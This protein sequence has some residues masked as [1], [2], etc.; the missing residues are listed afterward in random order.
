MKKR[1]NFIL[2]LSILLLLLFFSTV[3][4]FS[5]AGNQEDTTSPP[6]ENGAEE[7]P[8]E[9]DS[10]RA[11][12]E[13][14][15]GETENGNGEKEPVVDYEDYKEKLP[16]EIRDLPANELGE[17]MILMYHEIGEP[18]EEWVRTPDNFRRDLEVLYEEGYRLVSLNDVLDGNI[19][20]PPGTTP[21]VLTFDDGTKGQLRYLKD[22]DGE[23]LLDEA[24][25]PK[26]DS[27]CAVAILMEF[28]EE[29]PDFGLEG[30]F[31]IFYPTPFRQGD[32]VEHKLN[33]LVENGFEIGNHAYNHE[34]LSSL[35]QEGV[36]RALARHVEQTR[37]YLPGYDVRSLALPFGAWPS[38]EELAAEGSYGGT[39]Y[40]H[41]AVL[42]V[43]YYPAPSPFH[44]DFNAHSL[45]RVR[46][47]EMKVDGV[48]MYDWM[49]RARENPE[50]R[51]ISDGNPDTVAVPDEETAEKVRDDLP[52]DMEIVIE[53]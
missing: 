50:R 43:G 41:D 3:F 53:E 10:D 8:A 27:D 44:K 7:D 31:Y 13:G 2:P 4:L 15:E 22:E 12:G 47:S 1:V 26:L 36:Q 16:E 20:V 9:E 48:G 52:D 18:E 33:F 24:G 34:N 30:S 11:N 37:V 14:E 40:R 35:D 21:V 29:H 51:Y 19:E 28:H 39:D 32:M 6:G 25:E 5:C 23:I 42:E 49:E 17:V 46:A 45:P 38:P